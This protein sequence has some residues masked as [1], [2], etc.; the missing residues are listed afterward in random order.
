LPPRHFSWC[1][2]FGSLLPFLAEATFKANFFKF[3]VQWRED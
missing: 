2:I 1:D 3:D